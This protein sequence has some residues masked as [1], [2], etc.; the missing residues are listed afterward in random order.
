MTEFKVLGGLQIINGDRVC[1]PTA[2]K[3]RQVIALLLLSGNQVVNLDHLIE[4][5]WDERPPR[6]AVTTTQTYIYQVR[7][8]IAEERLEE[9]GRELLVTKASGYVLQVA[10]EQVDANVFRRLVREGRQHMDGGRPEDASATLREALDLWQGVALADVTCGRV[11]E[12]YAV[13]LEEQRLRALE[14]RIQ[15][16]LELGLHRELVG[17]LK[18][19]VAT[20]PL[21]EWFHGQLITALGRVGRRSEALA[22]YQRLRT[23]LDDELGLEPTPE[24]QRLQLEVLNAGYGQVEAPARRARVMAVT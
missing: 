3:V 23:V 2:P 9:P 15:A 12:P 24:L 11:L 4:E 1:T 18:A 8:L 20:H 6:S 17:E 19:L 10:P 22:A 7:K 14:L 16:D 13:L 21:N 5:L